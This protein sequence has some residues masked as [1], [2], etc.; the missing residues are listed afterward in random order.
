MMLQ[1]LGVFA[2]F[3]RARIGERTAEVLAERRR[4][5]KVYSRNA[6]FGYDRVD[7]RL[8]ENPQKMTALNEARLMFADDASLRQIGARLTELVGGRWHPQTVK[9]ML[10]SRM[11]TAISTDSPRTLVINPRVF[12]V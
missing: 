11:T 4:D 6:P 5:R 10:T 9:A 7:D 12:P 1:L 8:V 3:E 2:E